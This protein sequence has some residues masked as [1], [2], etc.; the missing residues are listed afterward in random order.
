MAT[1]PNPQTTRTAPSRT[2][3]AFRHSIDADETACEAVYTAVAAA[4][5]CSALELE[6]LEA[7]VDTDSL[8]ALFSSTRSADGFRFGFRYCGFDVTIHDGEVT[9]RSNP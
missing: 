7:T 8:D 3:T 9:V 5:D 1:D 6:P 4:A 2:D